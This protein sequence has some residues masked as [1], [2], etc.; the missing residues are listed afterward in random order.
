MFKKSFIVS[1]LATTTLGVFVP[2]AVSANEITLT[3]K[4]QDVKIVGEFAGFRQDA[5]IIATE[6]GNLHVPAKYVDCEGDE[7]LIFVSANTQGN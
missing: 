3:L 7:C 4:D 5:Y 2:A 1:I 6:T